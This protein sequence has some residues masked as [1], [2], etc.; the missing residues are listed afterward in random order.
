MTLEEAETALPSAATGLRYLVLF[1]SGEMASQDAAGPFNSIKQIDELS[2]W[3]ETFDFQFDEANW[4]RTGQ[5][6]TKPIAADSD[7]QNTG[8]ILEEQIPGGG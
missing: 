1:D 4:R 7:Y 2:H 5:Y 6:L 3:P 8:E